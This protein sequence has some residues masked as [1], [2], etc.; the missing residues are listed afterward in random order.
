MGGGSGAHG[1]PQ[2]QGLHQLYFAVPGSLAAGTRLAGC[3]CYCRLRGE[4]LLCPHVPHS[5][6]LAK[7]VGHTWEKSLYLL[8]GWALPKPYLWKRP[9]KLSPGEHS[10]S[11]TA[12]KAAKSFMIQKAPNVGK[13]MQCHVPK[14]TRVQCCST[15]LPTA[16]SLSA[17]LPT[18]PLLASQGLSAG[19]HLSCPSAVS[20]QASS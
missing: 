19:T 16:T 14:R 5:P 1:E 13:A 9:Q 15:P 12:G 6:V 7:G 20:H 2:T 4:L 18:V 10:P 3:S 17:S 8:H 11:N